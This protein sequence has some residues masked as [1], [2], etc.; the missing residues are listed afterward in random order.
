VLVFV[1]IWGCTSSEDKYGLISKDDRKAVAEVCKCMEPVETFKEKMANETDTLLRKMYRDSF[2]VKAVEMLP[3]LEKF[4]KLETKFGSS[5]EYMNQFVEYV[6]DKH[7]KC[8]PLMLGIGPTD[9]V[10]T[11]K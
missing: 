8:V 5:D 11:K 1:Y 2:E 6:R 7:P 4:E 3:C 9:S 10:N